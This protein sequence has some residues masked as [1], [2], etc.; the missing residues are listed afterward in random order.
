MPQPHDDTS[1]DQEILDYSTNATV[2]YPMPLC[3]VVVNFDSLDEVLSCLA[4]IR[5]SIVILKSEFFNNV[6]WMHSSDAIDNS[7]NFRMLLGM[8]EACF[9]LHAK[10]VKQHGAV[11]DGVSQYP[12]TGPYEVP[13]KSTE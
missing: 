3:G 8:Q 13:A 12:F 7:R 9:D 2:R 1:R 4:F 10:Y 5:E 6:E 11:A